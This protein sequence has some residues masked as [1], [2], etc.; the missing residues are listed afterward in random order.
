MLKSKCLYGKGAANRG[1][2]AADLGR[3]RY[4]QREV[5]ACGHFL[6]YDVQFLG[7]GRLFRS[8]MTEQFQVCA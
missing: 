4:I 3:G 7:L 6:P 8:Q 2:G 5:F 1:G